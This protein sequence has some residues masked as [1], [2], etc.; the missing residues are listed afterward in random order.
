MLGKKEQLHQ[1]NKC[2]NK[3]IKWNHWCPKC[4]NVFGFFY[5]M[6]PLD[7]SPLEMKSSF[8][9]EELDNADLNGLGDKQSVCF[10]LTPV[11]FFSVDLQQMPRFSFS[12]GRKNPNTNVLASCTNPRVTTGRATSRQ[13][14]PAAWVSCIMRFRFVYRSID[15]DPRRGFLFFMFLQDAFGEDGDCHAVRDSTDPGDLDDFPAHKPVWWSLSCSPLVLLHV[16]LWLL[17]TCILI[18]HQ[19]FVERVRDS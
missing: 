5:Q 9:A 7:S 1:Y 14:A 19:V 4:K 2:T 15:L 13:P 18:L 17:S 6:D 11:C 10:C 16:R 8:S 12:S 3:Q